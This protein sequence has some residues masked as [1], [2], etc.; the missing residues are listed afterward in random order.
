MTMPDV[1]ATS[2]HVG[3]LDRLLQD[4]SSGRSLTQLFAGTSD[5]FWLWAFTEGYRTDPRLRQLMPALP[6]EE[7]QYR[8]A[9]AAGDDTIRD[10]FGFYQLVKELLARHHRGAA[11]SILEFGC[12]WGRII[13]LFIREAEPQQLWGIDCMA[14]AIE[15]CQATNPHATFRRVDPFPPSGLTPASFDLVYAFSV[16]SHLSEEAHARW[17]AEFKTILRPGGLLVL[18]TRPRE[19]ILMCAELRARQEERNWAQGTVLAFQDTEEALRRYDRGEYVYE[20]MGGGDVLDKSFFGETCIP[21]AYVERHWTR[22]F[23]FVDYIDD[24]SRCLQNVAVVRKR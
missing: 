14:P 17:L 19:F 21:R 12:G 16:F 5:A 13:R 23:D 1:S 8:F 2:D 20:P 7:V 10:A 11:R 24:R 3:T 9:G 6:P 22:D 18:T 15:I 4:G